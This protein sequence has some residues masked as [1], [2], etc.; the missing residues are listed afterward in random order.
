MLSPEATA[1]RLN[2]LSLP[3]ASHPPPLQDSLSLLCHGQQRFVWQPGPF[4]ENSRSGRQTAVAPK[5]ITRKK[6]AL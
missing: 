2:Q 5:A 4:K 3:P 6:R 1:N